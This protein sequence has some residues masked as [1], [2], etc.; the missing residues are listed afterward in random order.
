MGTVR[1]GGG[2]G[3]GG[4]SGIVQ[5]VFVRGY[6][7]LIA[8]SEPTP[9]TGGVSAGLFLLEGHWCWS[10]DRATGVNQCA[11]LCDGPA[12]WGVPWGICQHFW[13]GVILRERDCVKE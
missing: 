11:E 10:G 1:G 9:W 3:G 7:Q 8:I 4:G 6:K 5:L 2:R 12:R 13:H